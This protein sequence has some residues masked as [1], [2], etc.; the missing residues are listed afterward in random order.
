MAMTERA[1]AYEEAQSYESRRWQVLN[2]KA[3]EKKTNKR[4]GDTAKLVVG[5]TAVLVYLLG[6]TFM[7][8]K[9]SSAGHEINEIK[10]TIAETETLSAQADLQIG[11]SSS[12]NYIESYA[13]AELGMVYPAANNVYFLDEESSSAIAAGRNPVV[14]EE[15]EL[16]AED[17]PLWK[18]ISAALGGF[19]MASGE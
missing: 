15:E 12:L 5:V 17:H 4:R 9:I 13:I 8:A 14:A 18:N 6:I 3:L 7:Q 1:Y 11:K 19:F 10:A 16:V 2:G